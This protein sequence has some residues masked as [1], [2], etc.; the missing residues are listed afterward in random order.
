MAKA[1][2]LW[3]VLWLEG[4]NKF[5]SH[6]ASGPSGGM[7]GALRTETPQNR[8]PELK[9]VKVKGSSRGSKNKRS[10][11]VAIREGFFVPACAIVFQR[12]VRP[13]S[14][15]SDWLFNFPGLDTSSMSL[16]VPLTSRWWRFFSALAPQ[17]IQIRAAVTEAKPQNISIVVISILILPFFCCQGLHATSC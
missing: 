5:G 12:S 7:A 4:L 16:Y 3:N 17:H 2:A 10:V 11:N 8:C 1:L 13:V 15:V 6:A 9:C 14:V